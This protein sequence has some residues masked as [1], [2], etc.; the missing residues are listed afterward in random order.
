MRKSGILLPIAGLPAKYGIGTFGKEAYR[1]VDQ[2]KEAGQTYWQILPLGATGYGD[3]PYQ[4]FSTFAGNPYYIDLEMLVEEGLLKEEDIE[5]FDFGDNEHYID[6][7]K[8]YKS[9]FKVLR[10]A[11]EN[12][13]LEY[14]GSFWEFVGDNK[15]WLEDYAL[16]MAVKNAFDGKSFAEWDDDIRLRKPEAMQHYK[17]LYADEINFYR[18]QQFFFMKQWKK[19]K[20]YANENGIEIIG[21]IPIYV[22]F[23]SADT[24]SDPKLFQV[25]ENCMP[26]AVAGCP[27]DAFSDLGQLWGNPLYDWEYHAKTGYEWWTKRMFHCRKLYDVVRVDHFRGFDSYYA[28]PFGKE[29]AKEGVWEKG[30]GM[31][32]FDTLRRVLGETK[33][34]AEDLGFLTPSVLELVR[35]SGF[36]GMKVL[37]FAFD[38]REPN[39]YLPHNYQNNCVVY[40]GTH[41]NDTLLGW[42]KEL[43][44]EDREYAKEY[45]G[46]SS[47][48][49]EEIAEGVI[50]LAMG[51]VAKV[52][53]VPIQDYLGK[54]G[55]ARTNKPATLGDNWKWRMSADDL[56][57][58]VVK[59]IHRMT[60]M[61]SRL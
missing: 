13:N 50:R 54:D 26:V 27:P 51:S 11:Y 44:E 23:D 4:S 37:Q 32:L 39:D 5:P 61:Y 15:F 49:D 3:S 36:P 1:F 6:Y 18:F 55:S 41:D 57:D 59:K 28:I 29:D 46:I 60:W 42:L 45:M 58:E 25:D 14:N 21:D 48:R 7:E 43:P 17:N 9:R 2:L 52:C 40:T 47:D 19:L 35:Q 8:I 56:T 38:P 24:W 22:A 33:I 20:Q 53:I 10:M 12:C 31:D 30:P 16:F 34:I